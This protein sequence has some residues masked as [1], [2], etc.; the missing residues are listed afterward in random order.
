MLRLVA[1]QVVGEGID[2]LTD[3]FRGI[4]GPVRSSFVSADD[5]SYGAGLVVTVNCLK[6]SLVCSPACSPSAMMA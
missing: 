3:G 2:V 4:L 6:K 5:G 1:H